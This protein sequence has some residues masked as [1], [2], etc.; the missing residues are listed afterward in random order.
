[1]SAGAER[2]LD[3]DLVSPAAERFALRDPAPR[4]T[5]L[6]GLTIGLVDSMLN[7]RANWGQ[8]IL[9]AVEEH[10]RAAHRLVA[11]E[12]VSRPPINPPP[13][14]VFAAAMADRY[15]ALVTAVG[16]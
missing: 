14:N 2:G 9:D 15:A 5:S 12:R 13:P 4:L 3:F 16:D 1:M 11:F 6:D 10:L 7:A 8:G